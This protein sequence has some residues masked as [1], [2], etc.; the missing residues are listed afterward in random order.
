MFLQ[1]FVTLTNLG[2]QFME[3][4]LRLDRTAKEQFALWILGREK[5]LPVYCFQFHLAFIFGENYL[6]LTNIDLCGLKSAVIPA[7]HADFVGIATGFVTRAPRFLL[8]L[9]Y[10]IVH[11]PM[12]AIPQL[13]FQASHLIA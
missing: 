8:S 6:I 5:F 11:H 2:R 10:G 3:I 12:L 1:I 9:H 4:F 13:F 7:P